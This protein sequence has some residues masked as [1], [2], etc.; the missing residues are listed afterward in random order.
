MHKSKAA[1][2]LMEL[3]LTLLF[4]SIAG[5]VCLQLFGYAHLTNISS[6]NKSDANMIFSDLADDFFSSAADKEGS[7]TYYYGSSLERLSNGKGLYTATVTTTFDSDYYHC[8]VCIT[9]SSSNEIYLDDELIKY[10]RRTPL[11]E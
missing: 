5:A 4:F 3:L 6:Q 8:N 9:D 10:E 7:E 1:L 2:F 11:N